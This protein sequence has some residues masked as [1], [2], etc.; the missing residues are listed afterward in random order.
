M[1][2]RKC[3]ICFL[4]TVETPSSRARKPVTASGIL[5]L[6]HSP[7]LFKGQKG[8]AGAK[9]ARLLGENWPSSHDC[10]LFLPPRCFC[11]LVRMLGR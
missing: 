8:S 7:L 5:A 3:I 1:C 4:L 2:D 9:E 11:G 10:L 6:T